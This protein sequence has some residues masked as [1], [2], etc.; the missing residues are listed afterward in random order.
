MSN[1]EIAIQVLDYWY[2]VE[3]L[4]QDSYDEC[5]DESNLKRKLATFKKASQSEKQKRKQIIVCEKLSKKDDIH[6]VIS[7]QA[8]ECGMSTWGNLTFYVGKIKRQTCIKSLA[9]KLGF[10]LE[11]A[12]KN[13]DYIPV[14]SFQCNSQGKFIEHSLSLST[15]VWALSQV[16]DYKEVQVASVLSKG[17]YTETLEELEQKYFDAD[18]DS[19]LSSQDNPP[20]QVSEKNI[21]GFEPD[22]IT[23]DKILRIFNEINKVY[24]KY[25]GEPLED[26]IALKYQL[27][28]DSE[29]REK[30][31]DDNYMG[32]SHDFFSSDIKMVKTNI[33]EEKYDFDQGMLADLVSYICA[34]FTGLEQRERHDFVSPKSEAIFESEMSEILNM[35]HAPIAKWPSRYMPALMQQVAI[36]FAISNKS[37]GIFE[38][39]GHIFSVNG[40]PGTGKTTLLK[41]IIAS[42]IVEKAILLSKYNKPDDA[43][44]RV[45]FKQGEYGG[46]YV[47]AS[48]GNNFSPYAN[49]YRFKDDKIADYGVLVTSCNNAAVENISKELPLESGILDS[50]KVKTDGIDVDSEEMQNRIGEIR[51]LFS[52]KD[53]EETIELYI[54]DSKRNRDYPEIYFTGYAQKFFGSE[55]EDADAWGLIAAPLGKKSN[56]NGFYYN[57]LKPLWQD[58]MIKNDYL[59]NRLPCYNRARKDFLEQLERVRNLQKQLSTYGVVTLKVHNTKTQYDEKEQRNNATISFNN[60]KRNSINEKIRNVQDC[61]ENDAANIR[62]IN[63]LCEEIDK[64]LKEYQ[65]E[66]NDVS[67]QEIDYRR[68]ADQAEKSVGF[69]TRIFRKSKYNAALELSQSCRSRAEKCKEDSSELSNK[70]DYEQQLQKEAFAK[71]SLAIQKKKEDQKK[72]S[73]LNEERD[74]IEND[75]QRLKLEIEFFKKQVDDAQNEMNRLLGEYAN[76]G[77]LNSGHV[78]DKEFIKQV[79]SKDVNVSTDAQTIN[80]WTTEEYNRERE[81]LFFLA[82]QMT[83]NFLLSSKSC[84]TNLCI[85]GQYWGLKTEKGVGK[86]VFHTEDKERMMGSLFN[87]LFLLTPVISSTFASVG[88]LLKDI[89]EP[90]VI[91]TLI[92]DEAGQAQPQMAVGA[93]FRSRR[94]IIVG[95]PKQVEPVVT[96][97][98]DLLKRAYS[99]PVYANYKNKSISVQSCADIINPFGTF[100]DDGTGDS[101]WVGCPLLVHRRCIAPMYEI[102]NRISYNGIMKQKTKSPAADI[103]KTFIFPKSQWINVGGVEKGDGNHFVPEQGEL[104]CKIVNN[105]FKKAENPDLYIITPFVSVVSGIRNS[106]R[107]YADK[108]KDLPIG[109]SKVLEEWLYSNIGTV[110]KFQGKEANEVIFLLGCDETVKN[111]YAVT[112]FVNNNIVNVAAT[113]AKYRLYIVGNMKVW[114]NNLFVNEAKAIIDTLPIENISEIN[115]WENSVEKND[116]L[117]NQANQLPG[118]MSFVLPIGKNVDGEREYEID[119]DEFISTIDEA[120]FLNKD[121]SEEQYRQFGFASKSE[122]EHL[123]TDVKKNLLMGMK[124]YYLLKPIYMVSSDLDASCCGILFCKGMELY[125]RQNFVG[126]LKAKFPDYKIK[127][128]LHRTVELQNACSNDFMIGTIRHILREKVAEISEYMASHGESTL[129]QLWWSSFNEKLKAFADRRNDC[130]HPSCFKWQDMQQLLEYE[131]KEDGSDVSRNP[132]IGGVF[133]E[134]AKGRKLDS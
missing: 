68:Q 59:L 89:K 90:G 105:A 25:I 100:F 52:V 71:K 98:L 131:F 132:R 42:N 10:S 3:L 18:Y 34:P 24:G 15:I 22:A 20:K 19:V 50:L 48:S 106:L 73:R 110:H 107:T 77:E 56:I 118:A 103:A 120:D 57:V 43:F 23:M 75:N 27:F 8:R 5:T 9:E 36:N 101:E 2:T 45:P 115:R 94:S 30:N 62:R 66:K 60:T 72:L 78:L 37:C 123:P 126:G 58:L 93:L 63:E 54:D 99:E 117:S 55:E 84:R 28:K 133:Y 70:I 122:F 31:D 47:P 96:D 69:L 124:I 26:N 92:I 44:E 64:R 11:Q 97:D 76:G 81:K 74:S 119:T 46:A 16:A 85:L 82:L 4:S 128:A 14:L 121:L 88:R 80:P 33:E 40:P 32:L 41:E 112:G 1:K 86:I 109:K 113:R 104:V 29:T 102:S 65:K 116:E 53:T 6:N 49:W 7:I 61:V 111:R 38:E 12:E 35:M 108:N 17:K 125:L 51:K 130:C 95:D 79:L 87:T 39:C 21:P 129:D 13:T 127:N 91:G 83:K 134:S 67:D 114:C